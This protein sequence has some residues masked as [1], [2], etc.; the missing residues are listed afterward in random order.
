MFKCIYKLEHLDEEEAMNI[1]CPCRGCNNRKVSKTE[2]CH[3]SCA[4][5]KH[6]RNKVDEYNKKEREA[7]ELIY[8]LPF[9]KVGYPGYIN[10]ET[11]GLFKYPNNI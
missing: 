2:N 8:M 3:C 9:H 1:D 7:K 6:Y 5:Y 10:K 4:D 11:G